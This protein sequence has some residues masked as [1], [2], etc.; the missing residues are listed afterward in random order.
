MFKD[1]KVLSF[2]HFLQGPSAVREHTRE[3]LAE[4]GLSREQIDRLVA[5]GL[6]KDGAQAAGGRDAAD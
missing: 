4:Y 5:D 1:I 3:V 6:V 2:T